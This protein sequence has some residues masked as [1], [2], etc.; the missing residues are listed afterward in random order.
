M[1]WQIDTVNRINQ[2]DDMEIAPYREDGQTTGTLTRVWSVVVSGRLFVR[3][4]RGA[5]SS[6]YQ[7]AQAQQGG[8]IRSGG[9]ETTV[10][11]IK[12][13]DELLNERVDSAYRI[14]YGHSNYLASMISPR[15]RATS[16]EIVPAEN[17]PL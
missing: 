11:F 10:K 14:K 16:I 7:A 2:A 6:W 1:N 3:A 12:V 15:A 5:A 13:D 8:I 4:Y 9:E 17:L